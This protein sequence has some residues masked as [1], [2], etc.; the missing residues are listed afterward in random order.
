MNNRLINYLFVFITLLFVACS[1]APTSESETTQWRGPNRDGIYPDKDLLKEWP[2]EGPELIWKFDQLG[3]GYSAP[4]IADQKVYITGTIDSVSYLFALEMSGKLLWKKSY[5]KAWMTNFPGV[6]ST[7]NIVDE[8][9]YMISGIGELLCLRIADGEIVWKKDLN[10]EFAAQKTRYGFSEHLIVKEDVVYCVPGGKEHNVIA[11]NRFTG[12]L[13]WTSK[14]KGEA[15]AYCNPI[16]AKIG[17]VEYFITMTAGS[18]VSLNTT[19][20][21]LAWSHPL[22]GVKNAT[23]ANTP[24]Y[25]DGYLFLMDGFEIGC[26]ML[27]ISEDGKSAKQVWENV[28]MDETQGHSVVIGDRI[29]GSAES[30]KKIICLDWNTGEVLFELK[31][32]APGTLISADN[33]LYAYT[34]NGLLGI[35]EIGENEF[36]DRGSVKLE[37]KRQ[38]HIS[39]PVIH[40]GVLYIRYANELMAYD[41]QKKS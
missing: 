38:I 20:G 34:Y 35:I 11:L 19:N 29:Y 30:K 23:H 12:D 21:E 13:I 7:P 6:R 32:Y 33:Y 25:R 17:G 1:Y 9:C 31:K 15:S 2:V 24:Y 40:K 8:Y 4:V 10:T 37:K 41:I 16:L 14:A 18:V 36:I 26:L 5:G 3:L 22:K 39:H 27:K 28:L